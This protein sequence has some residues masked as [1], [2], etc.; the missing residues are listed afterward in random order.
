MVSSL[1]LPKGCSAAILHTHT[2]HTDGMVSPGELVEAAA[3]LDVRVLAITDHDT[4]TG[5]EEARKSGREFGVEIIAGEEIQTSLPRGLHVIG[6]Y[7]A[8][9]IAHSKSIEWTVEQIHKQGGLAVVA[10]PMVRLLRLIPTPTGALQLSD[11]KRL[12]KT[13]QFDGIEIRHPNLSKTDY[14]ILD[15]FYSQNQDRLGAQIGTAD[16]H[17]GGKDML[18]NFTIFPG[19]SAED[20]YMAIKDRVTEA[21]LGP[22]IKVGVLQASLQ[23]KK[24]LLNLGIKRYQKMV[25]RWLMLEFRG[26]EEYL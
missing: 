15:E 17:F 12:L 13:C 8:E 1:R 14:R 6:L 10:H 2:N 23:M 20:L 25:G 3:S 5:V 9:P 16:C 7:L 22:A 4:M 18:S 26:Q 11:L 24:S 21:V 19:S